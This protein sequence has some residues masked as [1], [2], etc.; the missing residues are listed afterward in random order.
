M[1]PKYEEDFYGW[2][3]EN[4]ALLKKGKFNEVDINHIIEE[5]ENL[6]ASEKRELVSRLSQLIM[7]LLKWHFQPIMRGHSWIYSIRVQRKQTKIHLKDN[8][9]LKSKLD[10]ILLD[11]YDVA[12]SEA[13]KETSLDEKNFP[14]ECPYTFDQIIDDTFFPE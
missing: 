10:E 11:S 5:M 2:A 1:L 3:M 6:G 8:P 9:S 7:H 14:S 13:A 12:I 4:A